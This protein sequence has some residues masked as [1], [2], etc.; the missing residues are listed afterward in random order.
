MCVCI[1]PARGGSKRIPRKNIKAFCGKPLIQ[2]SIAAAL[3]ASCFNRIIVSTDDVE[4]ADI[5]IEAGACVPSLRPKYL[6]DDYTGT[7][8]VISYCISTYLDKKEQENLVCCLYPTA[9]FVTAELIQ[10]SKDLL[11]SHPLAS[12]S[13]IAAQYSSPIQRAFSIDL[14]GFTSML[15]PKMLNVR[16]QDLPKS[17]YDA[18]QLYWAT[19]SNWSNSSNLLQQAIA[20]VQPPWL[21]QDIDTCEDWKN[22]EYLF[23]QISN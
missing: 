3:D 7:K 11:L 8:D 20:L 21:V 4:I 22:A 9:P 18:G 17:Y 16:T 23:N 15:N 13:F 19:V 14:D 10:K 5:A 1:I 12:M 6:S 2:W